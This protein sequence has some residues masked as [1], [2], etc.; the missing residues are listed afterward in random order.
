MNST[1][2]KD[3]NGQDELEMKVKNANL[4][5][6]SV[7]DLK[8]VLAKLKLKGTGTKN[9]SIGCCPLL[10]MKTNCWKRD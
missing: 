1:D 5:E 2:K 10:K 9:L 8:S 6:W 3:S 7:D 4:A